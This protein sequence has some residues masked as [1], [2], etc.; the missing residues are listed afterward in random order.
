MDGRERRERGTVTKRRRGKKG[1]ELGWG[2]RD[3]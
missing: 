1:V 2:P 3:P